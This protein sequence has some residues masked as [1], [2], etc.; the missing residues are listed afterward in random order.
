[1]PKPDPAALLAAERA[2]VSARMEAIQTQLAAL[3]DAART[4]NI[5]DEHDPEGSTIGYERAQLDSLLDHAN[6]HLLEIDEALN[7]LAT[8]GYGACERCGQQIGEQRLEALPSTPLC[9]DCAAFLQR[10]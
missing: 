10:R 1:V 3:H 8:G 7:R 9:V 5:D 6:A 4:S 2:E